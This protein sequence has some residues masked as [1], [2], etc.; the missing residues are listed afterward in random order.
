[1]TGTED[2]LLLFVLSREE[3][4]DNKAKHF[5]HSSYNSCKVFIGAPEWFFQFSE[6]E[7]NPKVAKVYISSLKLVLYIQN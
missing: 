2:H 7:K 1:M 5:I 3:K 6:A 4:T